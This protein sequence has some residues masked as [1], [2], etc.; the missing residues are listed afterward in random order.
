MR[1]RLLLTPML[2]NGL[3]LKTKAYVMDPKFSTPTSLPLYFSLGY[4]VLQENEDFMK[5][6]GKV[7]SFGVSV[8]PVFNLKKPL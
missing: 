6:C 1:E 5:D 4:K 2:F 3:D 7:S 8:D